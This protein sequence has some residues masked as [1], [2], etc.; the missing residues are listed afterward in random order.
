MAIAVLSVSLGV[1]S[2]AQPSGVRWASAPLNVTATVRNVS[3]GWT[4][5]WTVTPKFVANGN[6]ALS[7][8]VAGAQ[9]QSS[10]ILPVAA[11]SAQGPYETFLI[12]ATVNSTGLSASSSVS[13]TI[14]SLPLVSVDGPSR[15]QSTPSLSAL[16]TTSI[17]Y[18]GNGVGAPAISYS[19]QQLVGPTL[20]LSNRC[21]PANPLSCA[22]VLSLPALSLS[23]NNE[24][25]F[26]V[27]AWVTAAPWANSTADVTVSVSPSLLAAVVANG[28]RAWSEADVLL[29]DGTASYDPDLLTPGTT[30]LPSKLTGS[31]YTFLWGC[32][33][34]VGSNTPT[35]CSNLLSNIS[36]ARVSV[37]AFSLVVGHVYRFSLQ[38]SDS[39]VSNRTSSTAITVT[40]VAASSPIPLIRADL[41]PAVLA[42]TAALTVVGQVLRS[43]SAQ[44]TACG[45][46]LSWDVF[47]SPSGTPVNLTA[48]GTASVFRSADRQTSTLIIASGTLQAGA[49]YV[50]QLTANC[51]STRAGNGSSSTQQT[52]VVASPPRGGS[53][54]VDRTQGRAAVDLFTV[55]CTGWTTSSSSLVYTNAFKSSVSCSK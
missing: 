8:A 6:S 30:M 14:G 24:Y 48:P 33:S 2:P 55:S 25:T 13:V 17:V 28:S 40:P 16:L 53:C 20:S 36:D 27:R 19:W 41:L 43:T 29:L 23:A 44:A 32:S 22:S 3:A 45:L 9:N 54:S 1:A 12:T 10:L 47:S 37:A 34:Q 26:R 4:L 31:P 15:V 38:V 39:R 50:L 21:V 42:S 18:E 49:S 7:A 51:T 5:A 52:V 35:P 46:V 11:L